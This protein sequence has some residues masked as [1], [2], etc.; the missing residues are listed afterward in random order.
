MP[1]KPRLTSL[2]VAWIAILAVAL[3]ARLAAG[4]WWQS[5]LGDRPF[6]FGDSVG[7]W[8]LARTIA[9]GEPYQYL[10]ADARVFRTPGYPVV[11]STLFIFG[12]DNPPVLAARA[13]SAIL[14]TIAVGVAGWWTTQLFDARAG[15]IAGWITALYPGSIALGVFVLSEAPFCPLMLAQLALWSA[16][17]RA[18]SKHHVIAL[19]IAAG[20]AA[21]CAILMRPSWL[22]FTPF[23]IVV[24]LLFVRDRARQ[25]LIGCAMAAA[26]VLC[27]LPWWIHN[28]QVTGRFVPTTLQVGASLYDGLHPGATG[29]SDMRFVPEVT[30]RERLADS[31][32]DPDVFEYRVD[33]RMT[34]ESLAWAKEHPGRVVELIGIKFLRMWNV[35]PNEPAFRS[36]IM[37][38]G[39]LLTY[40]PLLVLSLIG[41]WRYTRWGWPYA[42]AWLPAVYLTLLHVVF[43]SSLRYREPAT[44]ALIVLAAGVLAGAMRSPTQA[45]TVSAATNSVRN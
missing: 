23:A 37:R 18:V 29:A 7:Y 24:G 8:E 10:N 43:V 13:I 31:P 38:V 35:W 36:W 21:G 25:L 44:L 4:A 39:I 17:W 3:C 20:V 41:M 5:R 42:L 33:R 6:F 1:T 16:A 15:L 40:G 11:L 28:A 9:R 2:R 32:T 30:E 12:G 45:E 14:G 27:L 26:L 22:L 19:S 34:E